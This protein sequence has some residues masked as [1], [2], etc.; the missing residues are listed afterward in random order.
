[1]GV[2]L[3]MLFATNIGRLVFLYNAI[4]ALPEAS[5]MAYQPVIVM[6]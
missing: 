5:P 3:V 2:A 6:L 1:M 4:T